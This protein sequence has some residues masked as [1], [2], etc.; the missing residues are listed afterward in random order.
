MK[1]ST[2]KKQEN[3]RCT[4]VDDKTAIGFHKTSDTWLFAQKCKAGIYIDKAYLSSEPELSPKQARRFA[5][6]ILQFCEEI[7]N[8]T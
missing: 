3:F 8:D 2:L 4:Y 6:K 1:I 5:N 7:E